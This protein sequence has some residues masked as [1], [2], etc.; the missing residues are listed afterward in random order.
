MNMRFLLFMLFFQFIIIDFFGQKFTPYKDKNELWGIMNNS[1]MKHV[2]RGTFDEILE[3]ND[4]IFIIKKDDS[5]YAVV[6]TNGKFILNYTQ[7]AFWLNNTNC[8]GNV[9]PYDTLNNKRLV[10]FPYFNPRKEINYHL[11]FIDYQRN[12]IPSDYYPCPSWR[13][14][15]NTK[16]PLYLELIQ[17]GEIQRYNKNIDS[18]VYYCK[19]AIQANPT[20]ASVYYWGANLFI[21]NFDENIK[22]RNNHKYKKY[23]P[24]IKYCL[25]KADEL[26]KINPYKTTILYRKYD[27]YKIDLKD[28][29]AAREIK[30][31]IKELK[32]KK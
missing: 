25:D 14:T 27:F 3:Y 17:K 1:T 9:Y 29:K 20:N 23:Y 19:L 10:E 28:K 6:D 18:A 5:Y 32:R 16:L 13:R 11:F 2:I 7:T 4:S 26:E 31:R 24:W 8:L 12:C 22:A 30:D 15:V 21:Y